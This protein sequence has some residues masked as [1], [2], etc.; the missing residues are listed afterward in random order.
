MLD[1]SI[2]AVRIYYNYMKMLN[3]KGAT[4]FVEIQCEKGIW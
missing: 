2:Q 1:K 3:M 4:F